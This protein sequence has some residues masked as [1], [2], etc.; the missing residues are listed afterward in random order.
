MPTK[1][2]LT[3]NRQI[4]TETN[5]PISAKVKLPYV[6]KIVLMT[7]PAAS[8]FPTDRA[9]PGAFLGAVWQRQQ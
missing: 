5:S 7:L 8:R 4:F 1:W 3:M 9:G 6:R 2:K